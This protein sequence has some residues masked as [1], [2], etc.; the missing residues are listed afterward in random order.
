MSAPHP[1]LALA[2]VTRLSN[3][4]A[5]PVSVARAT[6]TV[7]EVCGVLGLSRA[8]VYALLR[9][10]ELP[11]RRVGSR[12]I[13]A[14]HRFDTWLNEAPEPASLRSTGTEVRW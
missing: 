10:G 8:T 13:I 6:Y 7:A 11:A 12:W 5:T 14:R 3:Y 1:N 4:R 2:S 9:A